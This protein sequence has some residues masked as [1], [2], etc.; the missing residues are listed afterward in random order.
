MDVVPADEPEWESDPFILTRRGDSLVGRGACD[1]KGF[2]AV[3]MNRL[4]ALDPARLRHPLAL[5]FT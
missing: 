4:A 2:L 1:M 5:V 3:A